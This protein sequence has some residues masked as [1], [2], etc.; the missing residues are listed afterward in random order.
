LPECGRFGEGG[1]DGCLF[2]QR[3]GQSDGVLRGRQNFNA[4][5]TTSGRGSRMGAERAR[6]DPDPYRARESQG[7]G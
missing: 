3:A 4:Q 1:D 6:L 5:L 2:P 7:A